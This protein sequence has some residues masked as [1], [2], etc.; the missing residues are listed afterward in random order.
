MALI[1]C[2]DC[3]KEISDKAP[4]CI[5]CG[6][7]V[8]TNDSS[9][10]SKKNTALIPPPFSQ[11]TPTYQNSFQGAPTPNYISQ[12]N[13]VNIPY[14]KMQYQ[15]LK[16]KKKSGWGVFLIILGVIILVVMFLPSARNCSSLN[17]E[18]TGL[19]AA[20]RYIDGL[21]TPLNTRE[22]KDSYWHGFWSVHADCS[23]CK[24]NGDVPAR[25]R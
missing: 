4:K 12:T 19:K 20:T 17:L 10:G 6:C 25:Y 7:P 22:Y 2:P 13:P 5:G 21:S 15:P 8:A 9:I 1:T 23:I 18:C 14:N 3:N 11:P 24:L 16:Q